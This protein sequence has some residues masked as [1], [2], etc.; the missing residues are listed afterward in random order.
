MY[1]FPFA[2]MDV[3]KMIP[4]PFIQQK[5]QIYEELMI[6]EGVG[7]EINVYNVIALA[8]LFAYYMLLWK[9]DYLADKYRYMPI[10]LKVFCYSIC[11]YV[12]L[13]FFPPVAMRVEELI[14]IVDCVLFPLL[15]VLIRPHWLGRI[16]VMIYALGTFGLYIFV[17]RL[18]KL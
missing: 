3:L 15:A 1:A 7:T 14:A 13:S 2:G 4:I 17:Y 10:L 9:Y 18:L 8:R 16:L 12:G 5:L 6:Y 11:A